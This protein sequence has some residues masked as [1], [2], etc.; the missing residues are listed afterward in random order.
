MCEEYSDLRGQS[1]QDVLYPS[2]VI[3]EAAVADSENAKQKAKMEAI[4]EFMR[5]NIVENEVRNVI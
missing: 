5:F 4:P 1:L 2:G 3:A